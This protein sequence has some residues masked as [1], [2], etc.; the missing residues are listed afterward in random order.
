[1]A[2][3]AM[4]GATAGTAQVNIT[5]NM[6]GFTQA[7]NQ[8]RTAL[9]QFSRQINQQMGQTAASVNS[10]S[11]A[12][13]NQQAQIDKL[14]AKYIPLA[15][16]TQQ[17]K[18]ELLELRAAFQTGALS[19]GEFIDIEDR[20]RQ[21]YLN[22]TGALQAYGG[23]MRGMA[24]MSRLARYQQQILFYQLVDVT[25]MLAMG[26]NPIMTLVQQGPQILQVYG[27]SGIGRAMREMASM[28]A[29]AVRAIAPFGVI[30]GGAALGVS[31]L[32]SEIQETTGV[33]V[34]FGDVMMGIWF[35]I[36]DV[37]A[38][39]GTAVGEFLSPL[40][41]FGAE[42]VAGTVRDFNGLASLAVVTY[43][44]IKNT[45]KQLP[46]A[47]GGFMIEGIN[48]ILTFLDD[49]IID[50]TKGINSVVKLVNAGRGA[51]GADLLPE[52]V[53]ISLGRVE[54]PWEG[55]A[56]EVMEIVRES[57]KNNQIDLGELLMPTV[58]SNVLKAHEQ[59]L[60][61]AIGDS[62]ALGSLR[63]S[64]EKSNEAMRSEIAT[65][66]QSTA[67]IETN[68][69]MRELNLAA[70]E[71]D[72]EL[73]PRQ[74]AINQSLASTYGQLRAQQQVL[75]LVVDDGSMALT[76]YNEQL[77]ILNHFLAIGKISAESYALTLEELNIKLLQA[78]TDF[79]S[80]VVLGLTEY[81]QSATDMIGNVGEAFSTTFGGMEDALV[82][83]VTTGQVAFEDL[84]NSIISDLARLAI[85]QAIT[86][87]AAGLL[88]AA[89]S[90]AVG[91]ATGAP[92]NIIP[93]AKG[94][95]F[96]RAGMR[97]G[98]IRQPTLFT[99]ARGGRLGL[100][101]EA[102]TEAIMP[103]ARDSHGRLGVSA[104]GAAT[105]PVK[106]EL[107]LKADRDLSVREGQAR[108]SGGVSSFELFVSMQNRAIVTG[109][110]DKA[111]QTRFGASPSVRRGG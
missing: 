20:L 86:G 97:S 6:Q 30:I 59:R 13:A 72:M 76:Q 101:G 83:F 38:V 8:V 65:F 28:A 27:P 61:D 90:G 23:A 92:M 41:N 99:F 64:I 67:A 24:N 22:Q 35:T 49:M 42:F 51:L 82:Q 4:G 66:G 88:S 84:I 105:R 54:N 57:I 40:Q 17:Y 103:L 109:R 5:G 96:D 10:V 19:R 26:Q 52:V 50:V 31:Q 78:Q 47:L 106:I 48:E 11:A 69:K 94:N 16:V 68:A 36:R 104:E 2:G 33:A 21:Q 107:V 111:M 71:L 75:S 108:E 15:A 55:Q 9:N 60:E 53:P 63:E 46:I 80:A 91:G 74:I 44:V 70:Q 62:S 25:Q 87:P 77:A 18:Q 93:S 14:R 100:A 98:M 79:G 29:R 73:T 58:T 102:G 34:S 85:R 37:I 7:L 89:I 39:V 45:W 110:S 3:S 56:K 12:A 43:D 32:R 1:M 81:H 95:V